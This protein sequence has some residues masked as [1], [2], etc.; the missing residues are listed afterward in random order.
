MGTV[1]VGL[2]G[3]SS[4]RTSFAVALEEAELKGHDI[5]AV[6]VHAYPA[7]TI[8][9]ATRFDVG[10][11]HEAA[12]KWLDHELASLEEAAGGAF[13]VRVEPVAVM[14]HAGAELVD[15]SEGADLLVVGSRGLGGVRGLLLGSV[16]TYC[17]HHL[18]CPLLIV[19]VRDT[20]DTDDTE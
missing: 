16:S 1:V 7:T 8:Y 17:S 3:S 11:L 2:D 15:A 20:D 9:Q 5:K 6:H 19:P 14:G 13:P 12:E 10:E 4:S 18:P